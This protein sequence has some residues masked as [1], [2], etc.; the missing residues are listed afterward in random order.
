VG[1]YRCGDFGKDV[2]LLSSTTCRV[3]YS[4]G[5]PTRH[6]RALSARPTRTTA[7][8]ANER[9]CRRLKGLALE[10]LCARYRLA[11]SMMGRIDFEGDGPLSLV[12][13]VVL[14]DGRMEKATVGGVGSM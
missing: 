4:L 7:M 8:K 13:D 10:T 2:D 3:V 9:S 6:A 5:Q 11:S 14:A 1:E 12:T